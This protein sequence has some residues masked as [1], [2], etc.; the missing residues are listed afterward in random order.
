[1]SPDRSSA[2]RAAL[3]STSEM[4]QCDVEEVAGAASGVEDFKIAE[5]F[6]EFEQDVDCV[7]SFAGPL[8][9]DGGGLDIGPIGTEGLNNCG[10]DQ[11]FDV[12]ARRV[13]GA[14]CVSLTFIESAFKQGTEDRRFHILPFGLSSKQKDVKLL[15]VERQRLDRFKETAI[16]VEY[17]LAKDRGEAAGVH[18][19]PKRFDHGLEVGQVLAEAVEQISEAVLGEE[20]N[21]FGEECE[22][23]AH[24]ERR[25]GRSGVVLFERAGEVG[26][27]LGYI[28]RYSGGDTAGI[29]RERVEPDRA[30]AIANVVVL[31]VLEIDAVGEGIGKWNVRFP[32]TREIG[33]DLEGV[34]DVDHDKERRPT[35]DGREGL[36]VLLSLV[37][38]AE[39]GLVPPRGAANGGAA[40]TRHFEEERGLGRSA[41]LLGFEDEAAV[42]VKINETRAGESGEMAK[43]DGAFENVIVLGVVGDSGV[44]AR[45]F[46][47]V[48]EFG[49]EEGV[50]GSFSGAGVL[51]ALDERVYGH[52]QWSKG[53]FN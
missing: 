31:Q 1:M 13:V 49:E 40:A 15:V 52:E 43:C 20:V 46:E 4:L 50:I 36:G 28:A 16:E 35:F 17:M 8:E 12:S 26:E 6:A 3:S 10:N 25:D 41:A 23:A 44:G 53:K 21:V 37:A 33:I 29:E 22:D 42:F 48:A 18:G 39:H 24:Q 5:L 7:L 32:G 9:S 19:L 45:H 30:E 38:R 2:A 27:V 11:A 47:E 14:E 51:P 34:T